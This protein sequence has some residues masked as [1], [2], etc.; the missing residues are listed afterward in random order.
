MPK[1]QPVGRA[2]KTLRLAA[3]QNA[4][5]SAGAQYAQDFLEAVVVARQIPETKR[6]GDQAEGSVRERKLQGVR[7]D[8]GWPP[9]HFRR[10]ERRPV[11][12]GMCEVGTDNLR[13][14]LRAAL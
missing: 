10:F 4:A 1:I 5:F 9:S 2:Q 6:R 7:L 11:Q 14:R 13:A 8:P 3:L 12:H